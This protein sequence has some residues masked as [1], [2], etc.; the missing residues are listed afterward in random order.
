MDFFQNSPS[1]TPTRTSKAQKS[2]GQGSQ[3]EED[4]EDDESSS[5]SS[6]KIHPIETALD[7][8]ENT[9]AAENVEGDL[10]AFREQWKKEVKSNDGDGNSKS[11]L[12]ETII[13]EKNTELFKNAGMMKQEPDIEKK[14]RDLFLAGVEYEQNGKLYEAVLQYKKALHLVPDIEFKVFNLMKESGASANLT[15]KGS[16]NSSRE[17]TSNES[18]NASVIT[19]DDELHC[20]LLTKFSNLSIEN[21]G[22]CEQETPMQDTHI[23]C[24]PM[25]VI[26]NIMKW[27]VSS[28]LDLSSLESCSAVCRGFYLASRS[29]D[30]WR[31]VCLQ[32]WGIESVEALSSSV[33]NNLKNSNNDWRKCFLTN[34]RVHLNGCYISKISY[35]REG[36]RSFQDH[37]L[38]RAW[39]LI[40]YYRL[41]RFFPGGK[42]IMATSAEEPAQ[43]VKIFND[44]PGIGNADCMT[45]RYR[46]VQDRV[47][48]VVQKH[49]LEISS[50]L[51][52]SQRKTKTGKG[53]GAE[54]VFEVPDQVFHFEMQ[55]KG[56]KFN[57]LHWINYAAVSRYKSTGKTQQTEF[58]IKDVY[59]YPPLHFSKVKSYKCKESDNPL[60]QL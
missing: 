17:S 28:E 9:P 16:Q 23:S 14:A 38:Y 19:K 5:S 40:Q 51:A 36:E 13:E 45:G 11:N 54:Y 1:K 56:K 12:E 21:Q 6:I 42:V 18:M 24:L 26:I 22:I 7:G 52:K 55:I 46:T 2:Q 35:T 58:N 33:K 32:I 50:S 37:E 47:I 44:I 25:E 31:L 53:K 27:V 8:N 49:K 41:I 4:E 29:S 43:A 39:H 60:N 48:C 10:E 59:T 20:D 15:I 34:P 57:Q 30:I 3:M